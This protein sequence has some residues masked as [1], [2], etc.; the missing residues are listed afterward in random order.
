M[1]MARRGIDDFYTLQKKR[2]DAVQG[3][4]VVHQLAPNASDTSSPQACRCCALLNEH[5]SFIGYVHS[6]SFMEQQ[7]YG[8][9]RLHG[10]QQLQH[11]TVCSGMIISKISNQA[12]A[13]NLLPRPLS[14][15]R[16]PNRN[17][18]HDALAIVGRASSR[19]QRPSNREARNGEAVRG[20][21]EKF[22]RNQLELHDQQGRLR[23]NMFL[24]KDEPPKQTTQNHRT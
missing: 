10:P 9:Q 15:P 23:L 12:G 11:R 14:T 2:T 21:V 20:E 18:A 6:S 13:L 24:C 16:P 8:T 7:L 22:N 19:A 4:A 17:R 5:A 3:M 1:C